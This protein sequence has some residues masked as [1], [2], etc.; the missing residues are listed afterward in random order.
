MLSL[1]NYLSGNKKKR[2]L[3]NYGK[4][5]LKEILDYLKKNTE[6]RQTYFILMTI[7]EVEDTSA[8]IQKQIKNID[9]KYF[10]AESLYNFWLNKI[11]IITDDHLNFPDTLIKFMRLSLLDT[12]SIARMFRKFKPKRKIKNCEGK[13]SMMN[14]IYYGGGAHTNNIND[15]IQWQ[16]NIKPDINIKPNINDKGPDQCLV[17]PNFSPF[18][19]KMPWD[20]N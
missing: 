17:I 13:K 2:R 9:S 6:D 12:Y 14:I 16:F 8:L 5:I 1:Y 7:K 10:T 18:E 19:F 11:E 3:Y 15:F 20:K 4:K